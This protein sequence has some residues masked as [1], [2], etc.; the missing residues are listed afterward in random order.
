M[1][2]RW[3]NSIIT[4]VNQNRTM[5][6]KNKEKKLPMMSDRIPDTL[7]NVAK[8]VLNTPQKNPMSGIS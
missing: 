8:T 1:F 7:D 4:K 6:T 5:I 3:N 2:D